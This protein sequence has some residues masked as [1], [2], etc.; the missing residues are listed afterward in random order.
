MQN[1][2]LWTKHT[3]QEEENPEKKNEKQEEGV[4]KG[5]NFGNGECQLEASSAID[6]SQVCEWINGG[7]RCF[8]FF[9]FQCR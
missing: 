8:L 4:Q 9:G 2:E 5:A 7:K 3:G 1:V 6:E